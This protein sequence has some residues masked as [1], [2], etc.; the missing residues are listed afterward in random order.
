MSLPTFG[1]VYLTGT[2][3]LR[4]GRRASGNLNVIFY[5]ATVECRPSAIHPS[6]QLRKEDYRLKALEQTTMDRFKM[7]D[8]SRNST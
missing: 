4:N 5:H 7:G 1:Q 3:H 2:I 6:E 8:F